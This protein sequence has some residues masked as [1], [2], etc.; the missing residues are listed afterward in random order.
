MQ[1]AHSV[2]NPASPQAAAIAHLL[3]IFFSVAGI[4][5]LIVL[6]ALA[7][8]LARPK[9]LG[10]RDGDSRLRR[11]QLVTVSAALV[12]SAALL[13]SLGF[14]DYGTGRNIDTARAATP[15][16][17]RVRLIGR[18]WWWAIQY[19]QAAPP[20]RIA[21]AN[22]MHIPVGRPV[23]LTLESADVIHSFWAPNLHG[24]SDLVPSYSSGFLIQA[25]R[26]GVYRAP[27]AEYCGTQHAKMHLLIVAQSAD[28]F[29]AWYA[30]QARDAVPP[31][32]AAAAHGR[33]V[34]LSAACP[35][36]HT[37]RGTPTGGSVAPDLT[38]IAS[39][40]T[41][42]A[43]TVPNRRDELAAWIENSQGIKP[44]NQMPANLVSGRDLNALL[45][46]LSALR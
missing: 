38:H 45:D 41:L 1:D 37:I 34:F 4:I 26:P 11:R 19:E 24:K 3:R 36:C 31:P 2:L 32:N 15:D 5:W 20:Y 12:L 10:E 25:D 7:Y 46:Y 33:D 42:A 18:Q 30:N 43:G 27:C 23:L 14:V 17:I 40:L 13:L 16:T 6:G 28:S 9:R 21:T 29:A 39:R 22:E 35:F 8:A 44:G